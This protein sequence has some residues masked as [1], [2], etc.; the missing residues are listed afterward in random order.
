MKRQRNIKGVLKL[1]LIGSCIGLIIYY[2]KNHT[3]E[4]Q[5]IK[6]IKVIDV[7]L[8]FGSLFIV[9]VIHSYKIFMVVKFLDLKNISFIEWFKIITVSRF[10]NQHFFQGANIYRFIKLKKDYQFPYVRSLGATVSFQWIETV[11]I[12][13][14]TTLIIISFLGYF[15]NH[16]QKILLYLIATLISIFILPFLMFAVVKRINPKVISK[17]NINRPF[18]DNCE[19]VFNHIKEPKFLIYY[20]LNT[21]LFVFVYMAAVKVGFRAIHIDL[22]FSQ[23]LLFTGVLILSRMFN[24]VPANIGISELLCGSISNAINISF[25][26]G[27]IISGIIRVVNYAIYGAVTLIANLPNHSSSSESS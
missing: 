2:F 23:N 8:L 12:L 27:I 19:N 16:F 5:R 3:E 24:V 15:P 18:I 13:L 26:S 4:I 14:V 17:F 21:L 20:A 1:L 10:I 9:Q 25:G 7:F 22:Q 11:S 6:E